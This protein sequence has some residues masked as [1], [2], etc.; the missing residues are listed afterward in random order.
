MTSFEVLG[1]GSFGT[2]FAWNSTA[3]KQVAN[4]MNMSRLL[5][6]YN[7][8]ETIYETIATAAAPLATPLVEFWF[9]RPQGF[10]LSAWDFAKQ[11]HLN[12]LIERG[13]SHQALYAMRTVPFVPRSI[14]ADIVMRFFPDKF[15]T[16]EPPP[17]IA[18]L[19]VGLTDKRW[20]VGASFTTNFCLSACMMEELCLPVSAVAKAMGRT[21]AGINFLAGLD[22]RGIEFVLGGH[23]DNPL[24]LPGYACID[25]DQLMPHSGNP[26]II[27]DAWVKNEPFYPRP[28]SPYW[29]YFESGYLEMGASTGSRHLASLVIEGIHARC[30]PTL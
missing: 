5:H 12:P 4:S 25:F 6:E 15:H 21:L 9:P 2:V 26:L 20:L 22:G 10:Y 30:S 1:A 7:C 28:S 24:T 3:L 18:H 14:A 13:L 17:F 29:P 19:L 16:V 27:V 8:L 23:P 11:M